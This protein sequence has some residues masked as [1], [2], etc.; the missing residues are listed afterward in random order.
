MQLQLVS[1]RQQLN[2]SGR[3][4]LH[5]WYSV[6][7]WVTEQRLTE[8]GK[9]E[10]SAIYGPNTI[11][12]DINS[13]LKGETSHKQLIVIHGSTL[14]KIDRQQ[15]NLLRAYPETPLLLEHYL[16]L[17]QASDQWRL[18]LLALP[19]YQKFNRFASSYPVGQLPGILCASFLR[20]TPSRYSAAKKLYNRSK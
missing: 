7:C 1:A 5:A 19:D 16:L 10:V 4:L 3:H 18:D 9:S 20:M 8:A 12:T 2:T 14:L 13:F 17:K 6:D 11:F 15:F